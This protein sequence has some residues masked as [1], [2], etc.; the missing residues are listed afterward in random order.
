MMSPIKLIIADDEPFIC[1]MLE[2]LI[3]FSALE[4]QL[5]ECVHDGLTLESRIELLHPDIVLTDISMPKQDGLDVIRKTREK[6]IDC[7]FVII[8]GYRQFEYAYNALKYDVDDYLLKP[9]EKTELNRVLHKICDEIRQ[10]SQGDGDQEMVR[11]HSYLIE[12]GVHKELRND[13]LS[14]REI[15]KA[16]RTNFRAGVFRMVK[17]KLDFTRSERQRMEDVSS[18]INKLRNIGCQCLQTCC[19]EVI[20]SEHQDRIWFL[21]NYDRTQEQQIKKCIGDVYARAKHIVDLFHGFNL[22]LC[23]GVQVDRLCF[24]E[25]AKNSCQRASWIRMYYG[26]NRVIF[27]ENVED[28]PI[29]GFQTYLNGIQENLEKAYNAMDVES[30]RQ[31]FKQFFLL[32]MPV[33]C[34]TEAMDFIRATIRYLCERYG[35]VTKDGNGA[36]S[37]QQEIYTEIGRQI[38][39]PDYEKSL[40][41]QVEKYMLEMAEFVRDKNAKPVLRACAYIESHYAEHITLETMAGLVNLNPIYFSNLFK[42][43]V[44]QS[45]TEYLTGYRMKIA[46]EL[47]RGTDR[48]INEIADSLGYT[49]A[50]YFSKVFK[51]E[52]GIKPTDY[53]K[54]YG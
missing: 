37:A 47:L 40:T 50:R 19:L 42:K 6:G 22:T 54:I 43:E 25:V 48:N 32:P 49:D 3:D 36:T 34:G 8:S 2:K 9:V 7:R 31:Q 24:A 38:S 20:Y 5:L 45:F 27:A 41:N 23:V 30:M 4:L 14:L 21:L 13:A 12:Q 15:N 35:Q 53:R 1:G 17:M 26:I 28:V 44:G 39:F 29:G 16:F 52:V 10:I 11:Q 33:L 51:K 46:K 18:V